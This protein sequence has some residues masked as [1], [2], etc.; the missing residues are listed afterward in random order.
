MQTP[1]IRICSIDPY[2]KTCRGCKR[3]V[4]EIT[5]WTKYNDDQR[6]DI[7]NRLGA[8]NDRNLG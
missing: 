4:E 8:R 1:C 5:N 7:I 3:T 6:N 2:T